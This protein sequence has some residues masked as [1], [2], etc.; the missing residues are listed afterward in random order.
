MT[1]QLWKPLLGMRRRGSTLALA[2]ALILWPQVDLQA[3][4]A[5]NNGQAEVVDAFQKA[6][7]ETTL[8]EGLLR[9]HRKDNKLLL[10][11]QPQDLGRQFLMV[12]AIKSGLGQAMLVSGM[13]LFDDWMVT[14]TRAGDRIEFRRVNI[15]F[16]SSEDSRLAWVVKEGY[17]D[18]ILAALPIV[19]EDENSGSLLVDLSQ[20]LFGDLPGL[21]MSL[22]WILGGNVMLD[23][24]RTR[25][26]NVK[27]FPLNI[28]IDVQH[29]F[30]TD[31]TSDLGTIPDSRAVP[32]TV[33]YSLVQPPATGSYLPRLADD[34]VG[35]FTTVLKDLSLPGDQAPFIRYVNRWNL[36]KANPKADRSPPLAPIVIYMDKSI[37]YSN[38]PAVRR[39]LLEWN[40]A[41]EAVGIVD[42]IEVRYQP[43]D[44]DWDSEDVRY[45]TI[46]WA[47]DAWFGGF[48]PSRADPRTGQIFHADIL[49]HSSV[50]RG[51]NRLWRRYGTKPEPVGPDAPPV[52]ESMLRSG[53]I[54]TLSQQ[55]GIQVGLGLFAMRA[56]GLMAPGMPAPQQFLDAA[57]K[58]LVMHEFGHVLGLRH[59]FKGSTATPLDKIH[60][61]S[62]TSIHGL[63]GSVMDYNPINLAPPGTEQGEYFPST[64]GPY[65]YWA[66]EYGYKPIPNI[67]SPE[68]ELEALDKTAS[69]SAEPGLAFATD[70]NA[71]G[72][73]MGSVDPYTALFDL[74]SDP[75][76]WSRQQVD[77]VA[78]RLQD[79]LIDDLLADGERF[80]LLRSFVQS[81]LWKYYSSMRTQSRFIGGYNVTRLH[82][83]QTQDRSPLEPVPAKIQR[84]ALK[85]LEEYA[86][87]ADRVTLTPKLLRSLPAE[88]W[89]HWGL[90][91]WGDSTDFPLNRFLSAI[92]G[93]AVMRLLSPA[94]LSRVQNAEAA[95]DKPEDRFPL[96]ELLP[97]LTS[98]VWSELGSAPKAGEELISV[99]RRELQ[100]VHLKGFIQLALNPAH[101]V[102]R[103]AVS[104]SRHEL[105]NLAKEMETLLGNK[106]LGPMSRAHLEESQNRI[107]RALEAA[108]QIPAR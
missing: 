72:G 69:R 57:I 60:D 6:L 1:H 70:E 44:A 34:R 15:R 67:Q 38:R 21:G 76:E 27:V 7:E 64:I 96:A 35:Y 58:D 11:L 30:A 90:H 77:Y 88:T 83:G 43:D 73:P 3:Q 68:Q 93:A 87:D 19:A 24:T 37:P 42:A 45:S 79:K 66:I 49:I 50:L 47:T 16:R 32:V 105:S 33:R 106:D 20:A 9:L 81:L 78:S 39:G 8:L 2:A 14:F 5:G 26:G 51:Y 4:P 92:R 97:T 10:E 36:K 71:Y 29:T 31:N 40:K 48:G 102:P 52:P 56:S 53:R 80:Q 75:L 61:A 101:G 63:A 74:S 98:A 55:L 41:F 107:Q 46:R 89:N 59:N 12:S 22:R 23:P 100:R 104:L 86:F 25:W 18:S 17:S 94:V 54:C 91:T 82:K 103:D 108:Y 84:R 28:E 65:D 62:Y 13:S 95:F 85:I 99:Q